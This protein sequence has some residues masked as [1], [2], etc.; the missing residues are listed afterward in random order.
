MRSRKWIPWHNDTTYD[1]YIDLYAL[2]CDVST[3]CPGTTPDDV[4]EYLYRLIGYLYARYND[5]RRS[6]VGH[7]GSMHNDGG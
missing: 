1:T 3:N 4:S 5:K 6:G 2:S 7:H